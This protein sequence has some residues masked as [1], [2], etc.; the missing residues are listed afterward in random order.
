[1]FT[2]AIILDTRYPRK[3]D[4]RSPVK[5]RVTIDRKARYYGIGDYL[6]KEEFSRVYSKKPRQ[7]KKLLLMKF[8]AVEDRAVKILN[9]MENPTFDQFKKLFCSKGSGGNVKLY[10]EQRIKEMEQNNQHGTADLYAAALKSFAGIKGV[11]TIGFKAITPAWLKD[12]HK[13][14]V[15]CGKSDNT[16]SMYAR[17]LQHLFNMA[18]QDGVIPAKYYPFGEEKNGKYELPD[19]V[20][21]KRPLQKQEII[22]LT[23]YAGNPFFEYYRDFFMLSYYLVGLNFA[24][25][26]TLK[27]TQIHNNT[28]TVKRQKTAYR[29]KKVEIKLYIPQKA[30]AII[31][32][33]CTKD[34]EFVF[35]IATSKD[36]KKRKQQV[37][38]FTRNCNQSLKKIAKVI[39]INPSISTVY[40][41]HSAASHGLA[42]GASIIDIQQ[43][44]GHTDIT[45]TS[46]YLK[47][48]EDAE[49]TLAESLENNTVAK[50]EHRN[51]KIKALN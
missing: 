12:Y 30:W 20:N 51:E 24:D 35:D 39:G 41:R 37:K 5:L 3:K 17:C 14:M 26:L 50:M 13:K 15:A 29:A 28:L 10:F 32:R 43:G 47:S 18:I 49:K 46:N 22:V 48:L 4:T 2:T 42:G 11:E 8:A 45:T 6:T 7:D 34:S 36:P 38:N 23:N 27:W 31:N 1:M 19:P 21:S 9:A 33:Y 44:L 25:L 40:A 16:I